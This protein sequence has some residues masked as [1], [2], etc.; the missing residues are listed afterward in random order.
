MSRPNQLFL[1]ASLLLAS[2]SMSGC[3]TLYDDMYSPRRIFYR[4]PP[5]PPAA[6]IPLPSETT[7]Y[8]G[9]P[10]GDTTPM[11][12][13]P[14]T[15]G[16][17]PPQPEFPMI[18]GLEPTA[19]P[20]GDAPMEDAPVENAPMEGAAPMEGDAPALETMIPGLEAA[21]EEQ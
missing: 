10:A 6:R 16:G 8:E 13:T 2:L 11:Q 5:P 15:G 7:Y 9:P 20:M 3:G 17:A 12:P 1:L 4:P 21:P 18:P 19:P 14:A